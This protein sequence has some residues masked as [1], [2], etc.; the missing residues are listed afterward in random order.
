MG[1]QVLAH[2]V[3]CARPC[4][5]EA[6]WAVLMA[7]GA[8]KPGVALPEPML[9][10]GMVLGTEVRGGV[11]GPSSLH[12]GLG[13]PVHHS[14]FGSWSRASL[15]NIARD[16]LWLFCGGICGVGH[17]TLQR[18]GTDGAVAV[19]RDTDARTSRGGAML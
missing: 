16:G 6:L 7:P 13:E 5:V 4:V 15:T 1:G 17:V 8:E 18:R 12:G 14:A 2:A 10:F 9:K 3:I 19:K 11:W